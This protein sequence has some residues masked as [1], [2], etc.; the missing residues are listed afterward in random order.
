MTLN[1]AAIIVALAILVLSLASW[2]WHWMIRRAKR[3][4][5]KL[6]HVDAEPHRDSRD[7]HRAW[8]ESEAKLQGRR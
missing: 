7:W 1:K 8:L 5:S 4:D 3:L 2:G 6:L